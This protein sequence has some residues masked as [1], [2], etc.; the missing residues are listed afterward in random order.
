MCSAC[1]H[2]LSAR[3]GLEVEFQVYEV[4]DDALAHEDT[5]LPGRPPLTR[6]LHQ[7]LPVPQRNPIR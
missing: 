2:K 5:T 1:Q 3:F 7:G 6:A 4:I